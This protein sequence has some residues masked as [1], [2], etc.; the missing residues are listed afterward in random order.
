MPDIT[1]DYLNDLCNFDGIEAYLPLGIVGLPAAFGIMPGP[2]VKFS[3]TKDLPNGLIEV[4]EAMVTQARQ[5]TP[6]GQIWVKDANGNLHTR[7]DYQQIFEKDP[8]LV[9]GW[10]RRHP[11]VW[12]PTGQV[13]SPTGAI[14]GKPPAGTVVIGGEGGVTTTAPQG[15]G[16]KGGKGRKPIKVGK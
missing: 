6:K 8:L 4:D 2:N 5:F 13:T 10:M 9:L 3:L 16:K 15:Q 14:A 12:T 11:G 7:E 1:E